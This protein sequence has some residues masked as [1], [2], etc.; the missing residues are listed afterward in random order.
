MLLVLLLLLLLLWLFTIS[1]TSMIIIIIIIS[2]IIIMV[3]VMIIIISSSSIIIIINKISVIMIINIISE[4]AEW[5]RDKK[6]KRDRNR[7]L[8]VFVFHDPLW[9]GT[10]LRYSRME[11]DLCASLLRRD[12]ANILC[13]SKF[14]GWSA[15]WSM[16]MLLV[17][18]HNAMQSLCL[19]LY[20]SVCG[21]TDQLLLSVAQSKM[22]SIVH[23]ENLALE[24]WPCAGFRRGCSTIARTCHSLAYQEWQ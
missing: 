9:L 17:T 6:K 12:R 4:A 19:G 1:I 5:V 13:H 21:Y 3:S 22:E 11:F 15:K 8:C 20:L 23:R 7:C 18:W 14:E 16:D 2:V 24:G 10:L